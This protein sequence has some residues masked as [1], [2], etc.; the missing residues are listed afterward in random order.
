MSTILNKNNEVAD[1]LD[2]NQ[3]I[4]SRSPDE[5]VC[6]TSVLIKYAGLPGH[7]PTG[8]V[9]E[10]SNLA[11]YWYGRETG[12]TDASNHAGLSLSQEYAV[13][14]G[15]GLHFWGLAPTV[16]AIRTAIAQGV[17]CLLCGA[18]TGMV[19][20]ELGDRVPFG[21]T[22]TGNHCIVVSGVAP[23]GNLL[24]HDTANVDA[25]GKVRPGPRLYDAAKLQLVSA[26]AVMVPGSV[27][28]PAAKP[29]PIPAGW[30]RTPD[31]LLTPNGIHVPE[32]FA[33]YLCEHSHDGSD[34]PV[35]AP[36]QTALLED[37]NPELGGGMQLVCLKSM[38]CVPDNP[39]GASANLK[40]H[41][42]E[43]YVGR[44]LD[45]TRKKEAAL[46]AEYQQLV[47]WYDSFKSAYVAGQVTPPQ[48]MP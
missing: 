2:V 30:T 47:A 22:P 38:Y 26:T 18:E 17:P 33:T 4:P 7:G 29:E 32:P 8:T 14:Q 31:G 23:D 43:E 19:D 6:Y 42:V 35:R 21:W 46:F 1:F 15:L 25:S 16:D 34:V 45:A 27:I 44:E 40:G 5:C 10:A 12:N 48:A 13:L 41:V 9:L 28:Q 3:F 24:V 11:Q 20:V 36:Y 39:S 37:S